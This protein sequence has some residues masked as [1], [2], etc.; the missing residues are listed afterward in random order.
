MK[1]LGGPLGFVRLQMADEVEMRFG[2]VLHLRELTFK[3]LKIILAEVAQPKRVGVANYRSWKNLGN[4]HQRDIFGARARPARDAAL[5]MR[6]RTCS[7]L[8]LS[9]FSI[10]NGSTGKFPG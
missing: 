8:L 5:A 7:S 6:A 1:Q 3:F 10:N 2:Q 4:S 9:S